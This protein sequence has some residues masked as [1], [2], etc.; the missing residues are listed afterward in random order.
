MLSLPDKYKKNVSV[1]K[2]TFV[3]GANLQGT[4]RKRFETSVKEIRLT[5]QIEGFD[6][7]NFVNDEYN[8]QVIMFLTVKL[9]ELKYAAFISSV[10]QKCISALCVIEIT[11]GTNEQFSFADKRLNKLNS[12]ESIIENEYLS[13]VM[14]LEFLS[15][16]KTLFSLYID[17]DTILNRS[18]KHTYYIEMMTKS[19]LVCNQGLYSGQAELLDS[20]KL[21]YDDD[22][23]MECLPMLKKLKQLKLSAA[24]AKTVSEKSK[25]NSQ[26]KE[27]IN[28][29][30]GLVN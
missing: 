1:A 10:V 24:K 27:I 22:K 16:T 5:Y 30:E 8:C 7:P 14:P 21:W 29:L 19:F 28:T 26:I 13:T 18:N 23:A 2:N 3:K 15:D 11:D 9:K 6:I 17:Y 25:C 20:K 4:E 12:K